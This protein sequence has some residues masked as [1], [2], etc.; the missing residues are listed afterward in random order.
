MSAHRSIIRSRGVAVCEAQK[1]GAAMGGMS[2]EETDRLITE[3]LER[4]NVD[5]VLDL[6]EPD[7]V[8]I[9]PDSGAEIRGHDAIREALL[10]LFETEAKVQGTPPQVF[11]SDDVALV[12]SGWV[13]EATG[14]NDQTVRPSGTATDVMRRQADGTWLYVIDNP[15][16]P[17]SA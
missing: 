13:M 3:A 14:P 5:G 2:P 9:N 15:L 16:G 12:L 1:E 17:G 10:G 4:R 11:I 7:G 8:F 6:F